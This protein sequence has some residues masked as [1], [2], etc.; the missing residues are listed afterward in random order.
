MAP[1]FL[2]QTSAV[3]QGDDA[4]QKH[5]PRGQ[6]DYPVTG[7]SWYEAAAY[8]EFVGKSLPTI[9]HWIAASSV[10]GG[11]SIVPESNFGGVGPSPVGTSRGM[12]RAGAFDLAGNVKEWILNEDSSGRRYILGGAWNEPSYVFFDPDARSP[13]ARSGNFGFRCAKYS[14]DGDQGKAADPIRVQLRDVSSEK[15][16]SEPV[17]QAYKR[18]YSYDKT[19]LHSVVESVHETSDWREEKI[20]FDAAYGNE[21]VIAYLY[22]PKNASPPYQAVVHFTEAAAFYER[23]SAHLDPDYL[24]D[25][26]FV[27][28]SGRAVIFPVYKGMFERWDDFKCVP[29]DTLVYRDHVIDWSKD[30]GRSIDYLET[31]PDI[32]HGELAYQ[33]TSFGASLGSILPAVE[34]GLKVLVLVSPGYTLYKQLPESDQL[35]FA[36]RVK[37]PVLI[38]NGRFDYMYPVRSSQETLLRLLGAPD[39]DKRRL[40]YD[41]GHDIPRPE[42]IKE[43]LNWLDKYLGPVK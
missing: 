2:S 8:A 12:S 3:E 23:S 22:L 13:F 37:A 36:P 39:K 32:D 10:G 21:G 38:L 25:Y 7:I 20:T 27:I 31:R 35:N 30:L 16:V 15:P 26:D 9:Y 34:D 41:T 29:K 14:I 19:P 4:Q 18:L 33:G 24:E 28:K 1:E 6:P 42:M 17:F 40:V 43:T 5:R 11:A